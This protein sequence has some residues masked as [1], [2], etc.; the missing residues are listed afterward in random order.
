[1]AELGA[2]YAALIIKELVRREGVPTECIAVP[3]A[4]ANCAA[5][6][7]LI[8]ISFGATLAHHVAVAAHARGHPADGLVII[9]LMPPAP[10]QLPPEQ[11]TSQQAILTRQSVCIRLE[12]SPSTS[13]HLL[14]TTFAGGSHDR[15]LN[16][17]STWH[18]G[19]SR[20]GGGELTTRALCTSP[21]LS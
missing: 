20:S 7:V 1:M 4:P 15:Q 21:T 5:P 9:E 17:G 8:G 2:K 19:D 11:L 14:C 6:Y 3:N 18:N 10:E 16:A 12:H 13:L